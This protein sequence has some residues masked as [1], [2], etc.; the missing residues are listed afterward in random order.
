MN[1]IRPLE[2]FVCDTCHEIIK[3]PKEGWLEWIHDEKGKNHSFRICHHQLYSPLR[4]RG[5]GCYAHGN[6]RGR[7]DNHLDSILENRM[8]HL[9][10][11]IDVG[12]Y[13]EPDFTEPHT[14]DLREWAELSRRLTIPY[15]EQARLYWQRA[16]DG[17]Y[18]DGANEILI[19]TENFLQKLIEE[20]GE[21]EG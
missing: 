15:Y 9:L 4:G 17:G 16:T 5:E 7:S 10:Y 20:Y 11:F 19:Y 14:R 21:D 12:A 8:A 1:I 2:Q 13:H 6:E 18:F 3:T